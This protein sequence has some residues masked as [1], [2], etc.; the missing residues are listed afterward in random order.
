MNLEGLA[1]TPRAHLTISCPYFTRAVGRR[2]KL[3]VFGDNY[4]TPDGT[5]ANYIHVVDLAL[6]HLAAL[7]HLKTWPGLLPVN[8][9]TGNGYSVLEM[10]N[11]M[12]QAS[13]V[14]LPTSGVASR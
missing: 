14:F 5:G 4:D 12:Q 9:G 8:L 6:G 3:M 13:A 1:R 10:V 7:D 2:E 11:A